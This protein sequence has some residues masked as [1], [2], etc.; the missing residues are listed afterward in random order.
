M[1]AYVGLCMTTD[2]ADMI[3]NVAD[4]WLRMSGREG[5]TAHFRKHISPPETY[6]ALINARLPF[7]DIDCGIKNHIKK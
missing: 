3:A 7:W 2:V 6:N 1:I 5:E 4:I